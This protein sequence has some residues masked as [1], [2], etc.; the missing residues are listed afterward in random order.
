MKVVNI[1]NPLKIILD[2]DN[3]VYSYDETGFDGAAAAA[4]DE[5]RS[6]NEERSGNGAPLTAKSAAAT[7]HR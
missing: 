4:H 1:M 7:A 5:G 3:V 6:G 2:I